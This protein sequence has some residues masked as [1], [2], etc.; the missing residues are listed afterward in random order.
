MVN[1]EGFTNFRFTQRAKNILCPIHVQAGEIAGSN[2]YKQ[3]RRQL[4]KMGSN[5]TLNSNLM[6]GQRS[7][8]IMPSPLNYN[9]SVDNSPSKPMMDSPQADGQEGQE[10]GPGNYA[11]HGTISL[12]S[13]NPGVNANDDM[14]QMYS[15]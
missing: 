11:L 7:R 8:S 9:Q 3:R 2:D 10:P 6:N 4:Q 5:I 14:S 12:S 13:G 15:T 1:T